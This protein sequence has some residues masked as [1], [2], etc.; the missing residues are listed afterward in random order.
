[1]TD[2][3]V[4]HI[5][6]SFALPHSTPKP[7]VAQRPAEKSI[8]STQHKEERRERSSRCFT[9]GIDPS[10][11][12]INA[13]VSLARSSQQCAFKKENK[14]DLSGG[15]ICRRKKSQSPPCSHI[16]ECSTLLTP[17]PPH[18]GKPL[19]TAT[20]EGVWTVGEGAEGFGMG[21]AHRGQLGA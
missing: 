13:S 7:P 8:Q 20:S 3:A 16:L 10:A 5:V 12:L 14:K 1:M 15:S 17:P 18:P 4:D 9:V 6:G 2:G 21:G 19:C 11:G